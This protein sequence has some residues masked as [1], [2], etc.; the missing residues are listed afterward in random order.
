[1][2]CTCLL[3]YIKPFFDVNYYNY[4]LYI[5]I[6]RRSKNKVVAKLPIYVGT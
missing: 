6:N 4:I 3:F 5:Y 1:M 2:Q